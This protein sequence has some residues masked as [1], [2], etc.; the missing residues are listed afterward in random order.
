VTRPLVFGHRGAAAHLPE[1]T[2]DGYLR[3]IGDGADGVECDVRLTRDGHLVCIHDSRLERTSNGTG[4]V[5]T[6]TLAELDRLDFG[7]WHPGEGTGPVP[8]RLLTLERLLTT[9]LAAGRPLRLLVETKHP[10]RYGRDVEVQLVKLLDQYGL[11][12]P[13]ADSPVRVTVMSFSMW[14]V[15]RVQALAPHLPTVFLYEIAPPGIRGGRPPFRPPIIGP[16]IALVR[17]HPELVQRAHARGRQVYVWTVNEHDDVSLV[18]DLGVDGII[19]DRPAYVR[20]R[21]G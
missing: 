1:H 6:A 15:R 18:L 11:T 14:A 10:T 2:V 13:E 12:D 3:A 5:S 4:R 8:A 19:T 16:G 20:S 7:S 21:V 17:N 9:L